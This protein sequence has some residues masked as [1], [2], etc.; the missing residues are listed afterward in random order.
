MS[1]GANRHAVIGVTENFWQHSTQNG[2]DLTHPSSPSASRV[3]HS[4]NITATTTPIAVDPAKTALVII[5]MQNFF[6]SESFG[7]TRG[8]GHAACDALLTHAIPAARK[9]GVQIIWLNWGLTENDVSTMPPAVKRAFGFE[10]HADSNDSLIA[11]EEY[12]KEHPSGIGVDKFGDKRHKGGHKMLENGKDGR[13]YKGLGSQCGN[14]TLPSGKTVDAGCLLMR[15]TWNASLYPPLDEAYQQGLKSKRPDVWIHKNR[16]SGMW[17]AATDCQ[18]YLDREGIRTLLFTGVNTDQCVSGTLTDSFSKGYDCILLSD[19]CGTTSPQYATECIEYNAA[20]TWG[21]VA[22]CE[23][24]AA[25]VHEM[26]N[27]S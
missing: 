3:A 16:M 15:D 10:A 11:G 22:S 2:F 9:A 12:F 14:V 1:D 4:L 20:R 8:A 26:L 27:E 6:L 24:F 17:G 23:N 7:R 19:G 21:F 5:D 25:G 18:K 13:I